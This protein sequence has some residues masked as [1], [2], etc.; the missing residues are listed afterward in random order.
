MGPKLLPESLK[1]LKGRRRSAIFVAWI[2][3]S[4][5]LMLIFFHIVP[6]F[7]TRNVILL[8]RVLVCIPPVDIGD[9]ETNN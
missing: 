2:L 8:F 4:S 3:T 9:W 1:I 5:Q 6:D 7:R